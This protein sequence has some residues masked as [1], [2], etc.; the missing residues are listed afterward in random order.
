MSKKLK[1]MCLVWP[2][3]EPYEHTVQVEIDI[4]ETIMLLKDLIKDKLAHHLA[5]VDAHDLTLWMC[6]IPADDNRSESLTNI[7]FDG[8]D[9]SVQRLRP[10]ASKVSKYFT[11]NLPPEIIHIFV[12]LPT[13]G[14]CGVRILFS[15]TEA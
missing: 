8:T 2:D 10:A 9:P 6:N 15:A 4:N 11:T 1:L 3:N 13:P 12:V 5:N 7:R 14:E